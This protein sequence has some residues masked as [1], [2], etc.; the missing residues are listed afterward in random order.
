MKKIITIS[1]LAICFC[2]CSKEGDLQKKDSYREVLAKSFSVD[3]DAR[4]IIT[5]NGEM[6]TDS[7]TGS[8]A[9]RKIIKTAGETQQVQV[10]NY[11]TGKLL[12]DTLLATP[13]TAFNFTVL[14][15]DATGEQKPLFISN[16]EGTDN[17]PKDHVMLSFY[18]SGAD[19]PDSFAVRI[20]RLRPDPVTFELLGV[21]TLTQFPVIRKGRL[22][23][24]KL[25]EFSLDPYQN[26]YCFEPRD[27]TTGEVLPGGEVAASIFQ[28]PLLGVN[29]TTNKHII[30]SID[31]KLMP[32]NRYSFWSSELVSY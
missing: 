25:L 28:A 26:M 10:K 12:Y 21:D 1:L 27:M 18:C 24:F 4:F 15:L 3:P 31:A 2:A 32:D 13:A 7:L 30:C 11:H 20:Y 6:L 17:I 16:D 23:E 22:S 5:V 19:L 8:G 14:Q 9:V 29:P